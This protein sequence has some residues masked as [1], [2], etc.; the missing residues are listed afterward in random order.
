[1][2]ATTMI[3]MIMKTRKKTPGKMKPMEPAPTEPKTAKMNTNIN[4]SMA[5]MRKGCRFWLPND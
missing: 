1:M 2:F 4:N 5:A 3:T